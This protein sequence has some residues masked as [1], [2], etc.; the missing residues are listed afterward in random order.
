[1]APAGIPAE[2]FPRRIVMRHAMAG[3]KVHSMGI[4]QVS[5]DRA[6][7]HVG[8]DALE[9][10][11]LQHSI[12]RPRRFPEDMRRTCLRTAFTVAFQHIIQS[13]RHDF[14]LSSAQCA[15]PHPT[16]DYGLSAFAI[17]AVRLHSFQ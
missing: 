2:V 4:L 14:L 1:M 11:V 8:T 3:H 16:N 7:V 6:H 17:K 15:P 10:T 9:A 13:S 5:G 12:D